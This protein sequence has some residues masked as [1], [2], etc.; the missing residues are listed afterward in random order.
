[1]NL[2]ARTLLVT[3]LLATLPLAAG[4]AESK[5]PH[6]SAEAASG[7]PQPH[8]QP[9]YMAVVNGTVIS[10]GE[11]ETNLKEA[12]R[13][14]FYHGTPPEQEVLDLTRDVA[15]RMI[16]RILLVAEAK[17]QGVKVNTAEVDAKIANYEKRYASNPRWQA[18]RESVLPPLR[19]RL[20]ED[21]LV[22]TL[23]T[24]VRNIPPP[25]R[26]KV[27]AYYNKHPEKFTE[28]E[29]LRLSLILLPVDPSSPTSAWQ[30]AEAEAGALRLRLTEGGADFAQL[31]K[32][33]S[34]HESAPAGGDL[35]YLH[36]GMLPDGIQEKVDGMKVGDLSPPTRVL[37][38][39]ALFK[40][41]DLQAAKHHDFETVKA[42]A[43]DLLV[44]DLQT[45]AWDNMRKQLRTKA[46][47]EI[48]EQRY[49]ALKTAPSAS[50][51]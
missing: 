3:S 16:D 18:E 25:S 17:R 40:F 23:E 43:Q 41:T 39:V 28:P 13:Q 24:R 49:P 47:L 2:V 38:G 27:L 5:P 9:P 15:Y 14:K 35:G 20:E 1:M 19:A 44:R 7:S 22:A 31:A 6:P 37:Q 4:A 11:F 36:R 33:R 34:E 46:K 12:A 45:E 10:S 51:K 32:E 50:K 30:T 8:A 26:E 21:S 29:K 48:N 42:R